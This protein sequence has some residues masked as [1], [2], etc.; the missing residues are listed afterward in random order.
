MWEGPAPGH[1]P[2]SIPIMTGRSCKALRERGY[3]YARALA[4]G[5]A[6]REVSGV[7]GLGSKAP[8]ESRENREA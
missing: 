3:F 2:R 8:P 7:L 4:I 6:K 1:G 5:T